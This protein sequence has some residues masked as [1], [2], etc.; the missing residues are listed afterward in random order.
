MDSRSE[1]FEMIA[2]VMSRAMAGA[3]EATA[4]T[5][6]VNSVVPTEKDALFRYLQGG[7]YKEFAAKESAVHP[8]R[9]PHTKFGLA[10]RVFLDPKLDASFRAGNASH[11]AGS[12]TVKEM[13]DASGNLNLQ[14]WAVMVKTQADSEGGKGWYW[15]EITS[16]T[17]GS[18]PVASGNGVPLCL[19]CHFPGKDFVLSGY[20]LP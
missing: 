6:R 4:E 19:G 11:P 1:E 15:Y 5:A 20:P 9:G 16:T 18:N 13:Y 2:G 14:G 3:M 7:S 10:I 12:A 17:S 8:T